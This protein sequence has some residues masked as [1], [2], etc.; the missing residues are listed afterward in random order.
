LDA[1]RKLRAAQVQTDAGNLCRKIDSTA[2]NF[3]CSEGFF[4][5]ND[6]DRASARV[7]RRRLCR[8]VPPA[9]EELARRVFHVFAPEL[10]FSGNHKE[11]LAAKLDQVRFDGELNDSFGLSFSPRAVST[12]HEITEGQRLFSGMGIH[13]KRIMRRPRAGRFSRSPKTPRCYRA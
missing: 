1:Q 11:L 12:G 8:A 13:K 5:P 9:V 7:W 4:P 2:L 10:K 3:N 6:W